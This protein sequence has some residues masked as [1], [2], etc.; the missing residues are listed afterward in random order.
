M[1]EVDIREFFK[2]LKRYIVAFI[3]AVG[4][5]IAGVLVYDLGFKKPVYQSKTTIVIAKSNNDNNSTTTLNDV[6]ASQKL[7]S[8]YSEIAKSELV[9]NKVVENLNLPMGVKALSQNVTVKPVDDTS[10]LSVAV[11]D[12]NAE[13]STVIANEIAKVFT[14]EIKKIYK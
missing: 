4:V 8:T 3:L 6:N 10:I 14:K 7:A 2:Y 5:A 13:Q 1:E 11:K 12:Q 9:L